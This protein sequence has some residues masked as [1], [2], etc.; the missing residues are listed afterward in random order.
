M[1]KNYSSQKGKRMDTE[2]SNNEVYNG[3]LS[4][5]Q[6]NPSNKNSV[7]ISSSDPIKS[8]PTREY[9]Q[10]TVSKEL[11]EGMFL[12]TQTRP[13]N[14]IEFLGKFLIEKSKSKYS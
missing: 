12:L 2:D 13:S 6:N 4:F 11:T 1:S 14:P 8:L 5:S 9:I 7:I 3:N 10:Q